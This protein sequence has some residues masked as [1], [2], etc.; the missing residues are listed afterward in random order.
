MR[1]LATILTAALPAVVSAATLTATLKPSTVN[2]GKP[3]QLTIR[4]EGAQPPTVT[5]ASTPRHLALTFKSEQRDTVTRNGR[6]IQSAEFT[7]EVLPKISG[8][9][10]VPAFKALVNGVEL[11]SEPLVLTVLD[12]DGNAQTGAGTAPPAM[13]KVNIPKR[14]VYLGEVFPITMELMAEGLRQNHLPVPQLLTPGIRFTIIR[15]DYQQTAMRPANGKLYRVFTFQT[16]AVAMKSGKLNLTFE[17][18]V[19]VM[20]YTQNVFGKQRTINLTSDPIELTVLPLPTE[21]RPANFSG[22]VGQFAIGNILLKPPRARTGDPV[23][24]NLR[25]SGSGSLE[26]VPMPQPASWEGFKVHP[27]ASEMDAPDN[28]GLTSSKLFKQMVVPLKPNLAAIPP[29]EFNYFDPRKEEY[30]SV[31]SPATPLTVSGAALPDPSPGDPPMPDE[32]PK[33]SDDRHKLAPIHAQPGSLA[34]IPVPLVNRAW[35]V[36]LP[37]TALLAFLLAFAVRQRRDYLEAHPAVARRLQVA[38]V[39]K[40]TLKE[41]QDP[42]VQADAERFLAGVQL[43]IRENLGRVIDQPAE[44]ITAE[45]LRAEDREWPEEVCAAWDRLHEQDALGRFASAEDTVNPQAA[46]SDLRL[47]LNHWK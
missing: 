22:A 14:R 11:R 44:G 31:R 3:A 8:R 27:P 35:F 28:R 19:T 20:D 10:A 18:T 30:I 7:Y 16:G 39:T 29:V 6:R 36:A 2:L 12:R 47:L 5:P 4:C 42:A 32:L 23:E 37:A 24:L 33:P 26:T 43:V 13:L 41:L 15:P 25:L 9:F 45:T 34:E 17:V 1:A 46:L 38:R 21:G 40:A